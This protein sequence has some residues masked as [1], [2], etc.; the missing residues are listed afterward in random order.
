[1]IPRDDDDE[2]TAPGR[3]VKVET[4]T[5]PILGTS[6]HKRRESNNGNPS[7]EA[8]NKICT[9]D[10]TPIKRRKVG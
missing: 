1:M 7:P 10:P 4:K 2:R 9:S 3:D 5:S 6:L 8:H